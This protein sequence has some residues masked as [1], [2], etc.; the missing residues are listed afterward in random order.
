MFFQSENT[1][2][3]LCAA[4]ISNPFIMKEN[5]PTSTPLRAGQASAEARLAGLLA[6]FNDLPRTVQALMTRAG[7]TIPAE[8]RSTAGFM[9]F[10]EQNLD[11]TAVDAI[12]EPDRDPLDVFAAVRGCLSS[13][14][15]EALAIHLFTKELLR[16]ITLAA[17]TQHLAS[18]RKHREPDRE[19]Q[20]LL[21]YRRYM[22]RRAQS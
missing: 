16:L 17:A 6:T 12:C 5:E 10:I 11:Q 19:K 8:L 4:D 1:P 18:T 20:V 7:V 9:R 15:A 13:R 2:I 14:S 3:R 22:S 21:T